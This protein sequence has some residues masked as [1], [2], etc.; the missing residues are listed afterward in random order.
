MLILLFVGAKIVVSHEICKKMADYL[1]LC[2]NPAH[3]SCT[4]AT[5][6]DITYKDGKE[7]RTSNYEAQPN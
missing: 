4:F 3:L 5:I 2:P 6:I 7:K 1:Y